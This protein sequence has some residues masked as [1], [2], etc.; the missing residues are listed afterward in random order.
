M[1]HHLGAIVLAAGESRRMGQSKQLLPWCGSTLI[2]AVVAAALASPVCEVVVVLGHRAAEV[3]AA[4]R[5]SDPR[6]RFVRNERYREGMLTSVLAGVGA[7]SDACEGFFLFLGDQP[8]AAPAVAAELAR[9]YQPGAI[10]VPADGGRRGHPVLFSLAY[11]REIG[12]LDNAVGLRQLLWR[13]PEAVREVAVAEPAI[14][15]DLDTPEDY[16]RLLKRGE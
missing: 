1:T 8:L 3:E 2:D 7:L 4:V 6:L 15:I 11:R 13:H 16:E 10:L 9:E 12:E 5:Q 14:H